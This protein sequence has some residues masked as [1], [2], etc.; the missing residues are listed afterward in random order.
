VFGQSLLHKRADL[1]GVGME[2][3]L[4]SLAH[5]LSGSAVA[6]L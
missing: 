5:W 6:A 3:G 2:I 4:E 1:V